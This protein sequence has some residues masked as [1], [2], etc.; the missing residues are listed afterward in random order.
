MLNKKIKIFKN[1][2]EVSEY[3]LLADFFMPTEKFLNEISTLSSNEKLIKL[4]ENIS[5]QKASENAKNRINKIENILDV[6]CLDE[7]IYCVDLTQNNTLSYKSIIIDNST[8][9]LEICSFIAIFYLVYLNLF[10]DYLSRNEKV[11]FLLPFDCKTACISALIFSKMVSNFNVVI[12]GDK[13][14]IAIYKN[15]FYKP[16]YQPSFSGYISEFFEDYGIV[17]DAYSSSEI[18]S[19]ENYLEEYDDDNSVVFFSFLSPY[20]T[21]EES[22]KYISNKT[23]KNNNIAIQKLYEETA[24]EIPPNIEDIKNNK[25]DFEEKLSCESFLYLL[26]NLYKY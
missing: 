15:E 4:Y 18:T 5:G 10:E 12:A 3:V 24:L 19:Y 17:F 13:T 7:D 6:L 21:V 22:L 11:N 25:F 8:I 23:F 1:N 26:E 14:N 2:V 9:Y 16:S 20:L